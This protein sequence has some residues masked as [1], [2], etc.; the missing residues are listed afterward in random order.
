MCMYCCRVVCSLDGIFLVAH[1][2]AWWHFFGFLRG[3]ADLVEDQRAAERALVETN[4]PAAQDRLRRLSEALAAL[5]RGDAGQ[6]RS[7]GDP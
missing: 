5:R 6:E 1:Y 3:E 7:A 2:V 4:E